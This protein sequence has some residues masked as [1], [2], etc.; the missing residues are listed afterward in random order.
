MIVVVAATKGGTGKT[1]TAVQLALYRKLIDKRD[2]WL[3]DADE[4]ESALT[5]ISIRSDS[6]MEPTLPCSAYSDGR[7]LRGQ[8]IA[9]RDKWEDIVI[10]IGG[11]A[12]DTLRAALLVCD[13]LVVPV[14][15]RSYD[16]W[17]L[18]KLVKVISEAQ[19]LGAN[20]KVECFLSMADA[21]GSDNGFALEQISDFPALTV[22]DA[23]VVRRKAISL[24]GSMGQSVFE[25]KP[26]DSKACDEIQRLAK[27]VFAEQH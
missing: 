27:I 23:P 16:V 25:Q 17:A 1:T 2:V 10:D 19:D 24:S 5:A 11:R 12:T 20:F 14:Q 15:P 4:Q 7:T 6:N 3:V 9:Q 18:S 8:I 21:Q 26:K 13:K 22:I